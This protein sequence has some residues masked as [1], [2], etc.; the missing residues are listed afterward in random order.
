MDTQKREEDP[1]LS[2]FPFA[3]PKI[4][5]SDPEA[6]G[7]T[8]ELSFQAPKLEALVWPPPDTASM[9]APPTAPVAAQPDIPSPAEQPTPPNPPAP[10]FS[11]HSQPVKTSPA[12]DAAPSSVAQRLEKPREKKKLSKRAKRG[13]LA[14]GILAGL[15][16]AIAGAVY[17]IVGATAPMYWELRSVRPFSSSKEIWTA[18]KC[19]QVITLLKEDSL[20][21]EPDAEGFFQPQISDA[22]RGKSKYVWDAL[23]TALQY[24]PQTMEAMKPYYE[25]EAPDAM[26]RQNQADYYHHFEVLFTALLT[27]E[28][29]G[30][31]Q[32]DYVAVRYSQFILDYWRDIRRLQDVALGGA[33][34][35]LTGHR[36][37]DQT[38]VNQLLQEHADQGAVLLN[39]LLKIDATEYVNSTFIA[40]TIDEHV[41]DY[42]QKYSDGELG[43]PWLTYFEKYLAGYFKGVPTNLQLLSYMQLQY[44]KTHYPIVAEKYAAL[45]SV[46]DLACSPEITALFEPYYAIVNKQ[47]Y[48]TAELADW[49]K[50]DMEEAKSYPDFLGAQAQPYALVIGSTNLED[51]EDPNNSGSIFDTIQLGLS[52]VLPT[53]CQI[54]ANL[55]EARYYLLAEPKYTYDC[56]YSATN[57]P[58]KIKGYACSIKFTLFDLV[59]DKELGA[60]TIERRPPEQISRGMDVSPE[61]ADT[62]DFAAIQGW[63]QTNIVQ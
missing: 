60:T 15:C 20:S 32:K 36:N 37:I 23:K 13:L 41:L 46:N 26:F 57:L 33:V 56:T 51:P 44:Y 62:P 53:Q 17:G 12:A 58:T 40:N 31:N 1:V 63:L 52:P 22:Q 49:S 30:Q 39:Y 28:S 4:F 50:T 45:A 18:E 59:D 34:T 24:Q 7:A 55:R 54:V 9:A 8:G 43:A 2:N 61:F 27:S 48:I 6:S 47:F 25:N 29:L 3:S 42:F 19:E 38:L 5:L 35:A 14:A 10:F 16:V 11:A 21:I